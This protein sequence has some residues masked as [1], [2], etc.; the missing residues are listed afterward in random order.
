MVFW[1]SFHVER[2]VT[3]VYTSDNGRKVFLLDEET[4]LWWPGT[5]SGI[6]KADAVHCV[7]TADDVDLK[8]KISTVDSVLKWDK[9]VNETCQH[10]HITPFVITKINTFKLSQH[11]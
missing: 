5:L 7:F 11:F 8:M 4:R 9:K 1:L 3:K 2:K 6:R 10:R